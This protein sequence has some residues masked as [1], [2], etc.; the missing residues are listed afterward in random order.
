MWRKLYKVNNK[1]MQ[2]VMVSI[3]RLTFLLCKWGVITLRPQVSFMFI[4][5]LTVPR[6]NPR[7]HP[8]TGLNCWPLF[9]RRNA[10]EVFPGRSIKSWIWTGHEISCSSCGWGKLV[11]HSHWKLR[12]DLGENTR[13]E[14]RR[15]LT[16]CKCLMQ[17]LL[18]KLLVCYSWVQRQVSLLFLQ[19][20]QGWQQ[21]QK[22][23][24]HFRGLLLRKT[25]SKNK[26]AKVGVI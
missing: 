5:K 22:K 26:I 13:K 25:K 12:H 11:L 2:W 15:F 7:V 18:W 6:S 9:S 24:R 19:D 21:V 4:L 3:N 23:H 20:S 8:G 14:R 10:I 17:N 16:Q 1:Q